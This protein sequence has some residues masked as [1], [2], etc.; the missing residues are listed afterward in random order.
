MPME[1]SQTKLRDGTHTLPHRGLSRHCMC[2]GYNRGKATEPCLH[3]RAE[4]RLSCAILLLKRVMALCLSLFRNYHFI[5]R[6][7]WGMYMKTRGTNVWGDVSLWSAGGSL[8]QCIV[9]FQATLA[10]RNAMYWIPS[11]HEGAK[12]VGKEVPVLFSIVIKWFFSFW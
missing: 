2:I 7:C 9:E 11:V 4:L 10:E 8:C 1:M 6:G 3:S 12:Y 5:N